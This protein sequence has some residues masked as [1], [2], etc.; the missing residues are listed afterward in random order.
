MQELPVT[1]GMNK[2]NPK[3]A[4]IIHVCSLLLRLLLKHCTHFR[5]SRCR[6]R[7][8]N[9]SG[10]SGG[11]PR[12]QGIQS[13]SPQAEGD[14]L[15]LSGKGFN[16]CLQPLEEQLQRWWSQ[17]LLN[18]LHKKGKFAWIVAWEIRITHRSDESVLSILPYPT[19]ISFNTFN[20]SAIFSC[21]WHRMSLNRVKFPE[22]VTQLLS[23]L[24]SYHSI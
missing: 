4:Y 14:A 18:G 2:T 13:S 16:S 19:V 17:Y 11:W 6:G 8:K 21:L 15:V 23:Y 22:Y 10:S 24:L 1:L 7:L 20:T 9:C 5:P 3:L 12:P